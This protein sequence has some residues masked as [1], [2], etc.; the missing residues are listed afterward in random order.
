MC[1]EIKTDITFLKNR[2]HKTVITDCSILKAQD[3]PY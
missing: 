3:T 1:N 2:I